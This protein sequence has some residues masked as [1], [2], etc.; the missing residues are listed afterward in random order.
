M[1][2]KPRISIVIPTYN[3]GKYIGTLLDSIY[4]QNFKNVEV[5]L[6]DGDSKDNTLEIAK[7]YPNIRIIKG[8]KSVAIAR[9]AGASI[10]KASIIYFLDADVALEKDTLS[11][12]NAIFKDKDIVCATG[13]IEVLEKNSSRFMKIWYKFNYS[14]LVKLSMFIKKPSFIGLNMAV[15]KKAFLKSGGFNIRMKTYEDCDFSIRASRYG[16]AV[17]KKELKVKAS[18][19]R[20]AQWGFIH[21]IKFTA[22]NAYNYYIKKKPL[23]DY[24]PIR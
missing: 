22:L 13:P 19:R 16:K 6:A 17:Y 1:V 2:K 18:A 24:K 7:K 23:S 11:N 8:K 10:A 14:F 21:Y 12:V 3:E 9:N 4:S 15:S 5:I 20:I